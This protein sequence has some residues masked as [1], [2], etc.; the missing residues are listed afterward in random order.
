MQKKIIVLLYY[1]FIYS[2]AEPHGMWNLSS[3]TKDQTH[4]P[5]SGRVESTPLDCQGSSRKKILDQICR[6]NVK[7]YLK[8]FYVR[9]SS[10]AV[11]FIEVRVPEVTQQILIAAAKGV[12]S[13]CLALWKQ[14]LW[15][16]L[17]VSILCN[18][19]I[20]N[21]SLLWEQDFTVKFWIHSSRFSWN[22]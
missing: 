15:N 12:G 8:K 17:L 19:A 11:N 3:L 2:L 20:T 5:C 6:G 21:W 16:N 9:K 1:F 14:I 7:G 10:K 18:E 4:T 13:F 22:T